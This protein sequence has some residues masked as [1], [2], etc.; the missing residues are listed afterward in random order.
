MGKLG[1]KMRGVLILVVAIALLLA[2]ASTVQSATVSTQDKALAF[3][4]DVFQL[5]MTK[6]NAKLATYSVDYP[7]ELG[8]QQEYVKYDLQASG[9][10]ATAFCQFNNGSLTACSISVITGSLLY[11]QP[12]DNTFDTTKGILERYQTYTGSSGLKQ[13]IDLLK[14]V[15][16]NNN[17][18]KTLGDMKLEVINDAYHTSYDWK[19]TFNGVD[20]NAVSIIY[21]DSGVFFSDYLSLYKIGNTDV[22]ISKEQ[23]IDIAMKY[24]ETYSYTG[25]VNSEGKEISVEIS[26]FNITKELT[27]T[28]LATNFREPLTFYPC[29]NIELYLDQKQPYANYTYP[30]GVYALQV[31]IWADSG[32][33]FSCTPLAV[34][35]II[36][37]GESVSGTSSSRSE[38]NTTEPLNE[39]LLAGIAI[40]IFVGAVT[41]AAVVYK[42]RSK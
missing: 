3:I 5:D 34:G 11:A 41:I 1:T 22:N 23:A 17:E 29:W 27:K 2:Q 32:E 14:T 31:G 38:N 6:Y 19:Y 18:T 20:Y 35:G 42:K 24:I 9:N 7:N 10:T 39:S 33:V 25:V 13:M 28:N 16:A 12:S 4:T 8:I 37:D 36:P 30:S 26:G 21:Q 15:N 40:A